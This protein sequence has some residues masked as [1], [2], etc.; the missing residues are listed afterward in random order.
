MENEKER[1]NK[2]LESSYDFNLRY[3]E[4]LC[5]KQNESY[6]SKP[7]LINQKVLYQR[8]SG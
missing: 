2:Q 4:N 3:I 1:H 8:H 7:A 6:L 5:C